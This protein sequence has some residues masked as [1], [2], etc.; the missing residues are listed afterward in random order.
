M[1]DASRRSMRKASRGSAHIMQHAS[2]VGVVADMRR[3]HKQLAATCAATQGTRANV[4]GATEPSPQSLMTF[5]NPLHSD[6]HPHMCC[7]LWTRDCVPNFCGRSGHTLIP[8]T[9]NNIHCFGGVKRYPCTKIE[10]D[11]SRFARAAATK[12]FKSDFLF[13]RLHH[14]Q[15]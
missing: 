8:N 13:R 7:C 4:K 11:F 9:V 2:G 5:G 3:L 6:L 10:H 15:S 14:I 12:R 1:R